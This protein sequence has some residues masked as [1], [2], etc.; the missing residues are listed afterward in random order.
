[1]P[2]PSSSA[3]PLPGELGQEVDDG[4]DDRRIEHLRGGLVVPRGDALVE[5]AVPLH[6]VNVAPDAIIDPQRRGL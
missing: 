3:R 4:I 5:V 1:M 2:I 6:P